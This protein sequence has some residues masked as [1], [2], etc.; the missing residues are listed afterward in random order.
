VLVSG[1]VLGLPGSNYDLDKL[2]YLGSTESGRP[3]ALAT[4]REAGLDSLE[5]LRAAP[6]V[7]IGAHAIGHITHVTAR[8]FAYLLGMKE[9]KFVVGYSGPER[10][11]ALIR[12]EVDASTMSPATIQQNP[13]LL[14]KTHLHTV[15]N[16]PRGNY[17]PAYPRQLPEIDLF[18]KTQQDRE[19]LQLYRAFLYPRWPYFLPPATPKELVV[20]LR[21]AMAK[22]FDDP[23]FAAEFKKLTGSEP[24]PLTGKE[25]E[26]AVRNL[27]RDPEVIAVYKKLADSGPLPAR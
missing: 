15:V 16:L 21:D 22:A 23:G 17:H 12:G 1:P 8:L 14:E 6:G 9:P 25:V 19:L 3:T 26:E 20:T 10:D 13:E 7:R 4:R 2:I 5:K 11:V 24:S 18:A 27:T